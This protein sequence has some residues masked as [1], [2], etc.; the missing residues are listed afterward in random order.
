MS[1][2]NQKNIKINFFTSSEELISLSEEDTKIV[3]TSLD[4]TISLD[5]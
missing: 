2:N 1:E 3:F 4:N 5:Y